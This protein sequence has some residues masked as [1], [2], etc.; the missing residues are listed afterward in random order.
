MTPLSC[1]VA[2]E[3]LEA[4]YDDELPVDR[5]IAVSSHLDQCESCASALAELESL[6]SSL[7]SGAPGRVPLP[8]DEAAGH[9]SAIVNRVKV[10]NDA[11]LAMRVR[12][13]FDDR[14]ILYAGL[15]AAA[16]TV[17]CLV[18]MLSMMRFATK[19]RSDSLAGMMNV[20]S[21]PV[22]EE[23]PLVIRPIV[24]DARVM[25]PRALDSMF[26]SGDFGDEVL[27]L[28][29][30]VTTEGRL[31]NLAVLDANSDVDMP[32]AASDAKRYESLFAAVSRVQFEPVIKEG[33]PVAVNMVWF[34]ANTTVR[35]RK[36]IRGGTPA[37]NSH[38]Q[39][40]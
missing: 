19:E 14:H 26:S 10:E 6:G 5:K 8:C 16:A 31:A 36:H 7:R 29:G 35:G 13:L 12:E 18:I 20:L 23:H 30:V 15:G 11:S 24:V 39:V 3:N 17:A 40:T 21:V 37:S 4:F 38:R 28:S 22:V 27:A 1:A 34:V 33:N 32:M 9:V 25:M 2:L